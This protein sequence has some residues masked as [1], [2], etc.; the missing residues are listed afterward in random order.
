M[1]KEIAQTFSIKKT[2]KGTLPSVPFEDIKNEVLGGKYELSLVLIG[3]AL[4]KRL[5]SEHKNKSTPTNVLSF[6]LSRTEGE[7]F[8]NVR[9]ATRDAR[10]Y[11]HSWEQHLAFLFIH[12]CLHLK[13]M[14]HSPKMERAEEKLLRAFLS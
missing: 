8:L 12:A 13:G 14:T 4:A 1:G 5:N 6:P 2:T 10:T 11:G 3:D 7:I 9:R